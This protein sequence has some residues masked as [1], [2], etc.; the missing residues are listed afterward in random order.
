MKNFRGDYKEADKI[1][2]LLD[3]QKI[4]YGSKVANSFI[5]GAA[6]HGDADMLN[7]HIEISDCDDNG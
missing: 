6:V 7:E 4:R 1:L 2:H 5:L 3:E